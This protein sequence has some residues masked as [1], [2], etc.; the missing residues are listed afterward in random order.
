MELYKAKIVMLKDTMRIALDK[1]GDIKS[2]TVAI[3]GEVQ[4]EPNFSEVV[5]KRVLGTT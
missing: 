5:Y 3:P 1:W 4:K 2:T